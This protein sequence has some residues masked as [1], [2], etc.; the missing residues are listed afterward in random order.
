[1]VKI[2][3]VKTSLVVVS[4]AAGVIAGGKSAAEQ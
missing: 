4:D 1:M 3:H 2:R